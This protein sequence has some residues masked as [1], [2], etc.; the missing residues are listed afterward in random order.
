VADGFP[1]C[2]T[3]VDEEGRSLDLE[4]DFLREGILYDETLYEDTIDTHYKTNKES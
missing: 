1:P 3:A 2:G 4:L